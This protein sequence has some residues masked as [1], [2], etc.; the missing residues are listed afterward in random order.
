MRVPADPLSEC[1]GI[2]RQIEAQHLA[3]NLRARV[4]G[5]HSSGQLVHLGHKLASRTYTLEHILVPNRCLENRGISQRFGNRALNGFLDV[6][7]F[8][9]TLTA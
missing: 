3:D 4:T 2:Q 7:R 5:N 6:K 8:P 1:I 9:F